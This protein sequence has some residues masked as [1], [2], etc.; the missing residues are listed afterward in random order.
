VTTT[1]TDRYIAATVRHVSGRHRREIDRELR[2]AIADDIDARTALGEPPAQAEYAALNELG[3]PAHLATRYADRATVLIGPET[4][5][6]YVRALGVLCATVLPIVYVVQDIGY[7]V[8]G[9]N[10][11]AIIFGP[12]GTTLT[13]AMYLIACV[14]GLF[15]LVDRMGNEHRREGDAAGEWAP[16]QLP[17]A[18]AGQPTA[19]SDVIT[20]IVL[21]ALLVVALFVQRVSPVTTAAGAQV[22]IIDPALWGFWVFYFIAVVVLAIG[23]AVVNLRLGRWTTATAV[24]GTV[25][26][27]AAT[28][29]LAWLFWQAR[30]LN[31][32][33][34]A[35]AL[36]TPGSWISWLAIVVLALITAGVLLKTWRHR[37]R[38]TTTPS[39]PGKEEQ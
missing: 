7:W 16:D 3:D 15:V 9:E 10:A 2:A 6:S 36:V 24:I 25:L 32:A 34:D 28:G 1:L 38:Q 22:P 11:G 37:D 18:E 4:Y 39:H 35:R 21:G 26:A 17:F 5:R 13:V 23:L 12:L 33:L 19:W 20:G 27:L 29:P 30:V 14:T 31:H 8:R